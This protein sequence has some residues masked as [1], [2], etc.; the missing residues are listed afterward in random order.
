MPN[1][2]NSAK[3]GAMKTY[4]ASRSGRRGCQRDRSGSRGGGTIRPGVLT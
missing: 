1:A 2:A 3:N 4:G